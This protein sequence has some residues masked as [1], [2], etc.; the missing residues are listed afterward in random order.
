MKASYDEILKSD[1]MRYLS[2]NLISNDLVEGRHADAELHDWR[3]Q[4]GR[5]LTH[6]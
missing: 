1:M 5:K 3:V 6:S 2:A 4:L